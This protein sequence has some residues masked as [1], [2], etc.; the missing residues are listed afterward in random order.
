MWM[1]SL[2]ENGAREC[3][4][5]NEGARVSEWE[6]EPNVAIARN[7]RIFYRFNISRRLSAL[8]LGSHGIQIVHFIKLNSLFFFFQLFCMVLSLPPLFFVF[9]FRICVA[10]QKKKCEEPNWNARWL[11]R[12]PLSSF[13]IHSSCTHTPVQRSKWLNEKKNSRRRQNKCKNN[14]KSNCMSSS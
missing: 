9:R 5:W 1:R 14:N 11:I 8:R 10:S 7:Q 3:W 4:S 13:V 6:R 2:P 12:W